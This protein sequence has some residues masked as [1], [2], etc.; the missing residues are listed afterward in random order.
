MN[1]EEGWLSIE[2]ALSHMFPSM[3]KFEITER[4]NR[5]PRICV[6]YAYWGADKQ[7]DVTPDMMFQACKWD[8]IHLMLADKP[9]AMEAIDNFKEETEYVILNGQWPLKYSFL[10]VK[11]ARKTARQVRFERD[12]RDRLQKP[13]YYNKKRER[14]QAY[15]QKRKHSEVWA[16]DPADEG[17]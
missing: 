9:K 1:A 5:L 6:I 3:D 14:D 2:D 4:M 15:R 12:C 13:E 7:K 11:N 17:L 10:L 8:N 16:A